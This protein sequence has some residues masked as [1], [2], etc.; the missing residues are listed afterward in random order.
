LKIADFEG[1]VTASTRGWPLSAARGAFPAGNVSTPAT[2]Y[3]Y[4]LGTAPWSMPLPASGAVRREPTLSNKQ[5]TT[6]IAAR[7]GGLSG[8]HP[9]WDPV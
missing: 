3:A 8:P 1:Q 9:D 6:R 2:G 4:V 7:S 5:H